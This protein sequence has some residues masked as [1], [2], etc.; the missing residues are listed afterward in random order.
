[1]KHCLPFFI[2]FFAA[3]CTNAQQPQNKAAIALQHNASH[4][5]GGNQAFVPIKNIQWAFKTNGKIFSS[6]AISKG[7]VFIGSE[8][9]SLYAIN[10]KTG[11]QKWKFVTAGAV[12]SSPAV[13]GSNV[14]MGSYD[15][16]YY[17]IDAATGK[18]KWKFKTGGEKHVGDT[19]YWG[20]KPAGE[21]MNDLW[22]C[23]LSSPI[24]Y[25][26]KDGP[27]VCFGSSDGNVYAVNARTGK[28]KWTFAT[29][30]IVHASPAL[31]NGTIYIGSWDTFLYAINA[32]TGKQKW[33]FKTGAQMAMT[34]IQATATI[35][36]GIVYF[37]ARDAHLY[38]L[39]AATG[40]VVWQY[41]TQNS[42]VISSVTIS[43]NVLYVGTSDTFLLLALDA[44]TGHEKFRFKTNGYVFGKPAIAGSTAYIGDFTGNIFSVDIN[45]PEKNWATFSTA[46][47]KKYAVAT[48]KN[49]TLNF[50]Y[51]AKNT[52]LYLY[53]ANKKVMDGFYQL[54]SIASSLLVVKNVLYAGSADGYLYALNLK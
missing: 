34:G 37:G 11:K 9:K 5:P 29:K 26:S 15:G 48:L 13:Y 27:T 8:D 7:I 41:D 45:A 42:W 33:K 31:Y 28:L 1:M 24:I 21:Y 30:G 44:A 49:D 10:I 4:I 35:Q 25:K 18:Q 47:R 43:N 50:M 16:Y 46:S 53:A 17:A 39:N 32:A 20:M 40:S 52:D 36:N 23:F 54:G 3:H 14:Y 12:H 38:A 6:P 51:A 22:D 2:C 19:S